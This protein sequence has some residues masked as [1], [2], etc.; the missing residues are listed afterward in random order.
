MYS[1][2]E[3]TQ[4]AFDELFSL[5]YEP[6]ALPAKEYMDSLND[7]KLF[8]ERII[9]RIRILGYDGEEEVNKIVAYILKR[10]E[11]EKIQISRQNITNWLTKGFPSSSEHGREN[12]YRLCFALQM[13]AEETK[14]FFLKAYLERPFNF[15]NLHESVYYY[16]LKHA[17]TY[18]EALQIISRIEGIPVRENIYADDVT[19]EIGRAID[20]V[21]NEEEL[22]NYLVENRSGFTVQNQ[23]ATEQIKQLL[24]KCLEFL[25]EDKELVLPKQNRNGKKIKNIDELLTVMYGYSARATCGYE[26]K[27][28]K[29][30]P[31]SVYI[32][33]ISESAFPELI[34]RN[35][36]QRQ[37][38]ENI[39]KGKATSD[40]IR[41]ALIMLTFFHYFADAMIRGENVEAGFFDEF[42]DELNYRLATCGYVQLYWR[43]PYDWMIGCCA[44]ALNP[45]DELRKFIEVYYLERDNVHQKVTH[46]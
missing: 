37:Q 16:C 20:R 17:K 8:S 41:K 40:V 9:K 7:L 43:N 46:Y 21:K 2:G 1:D 26:E 29:R 6:E 5:D 19:E 35:F 33:S 38:F 44:C 39:L 42:T 25:V 11:N 23:T 45:L 10:C 28:G 30:I 22:I 14:E 27:N 4:L 34:R 13:N 24:D 15:K 36:P 18:Q 12:V 3:K 31:K 32:K